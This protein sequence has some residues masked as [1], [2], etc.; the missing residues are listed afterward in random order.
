MHRD[1][2]TLIEAVRGWDEGV[3]QIASKTIRQSRSLPAN[4]EVMRPGTAQAVKDL[5]DWAD[6]VVVTLKPN[7]HALRHY[8]GCRGC[9]VRPAGNMH[10]HGRVAC[11]LR[12]P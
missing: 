6:L 3:V 7:L 4:V 2:D 5:Y 10:R 1:W 9:V 12:R 11:L 8:C